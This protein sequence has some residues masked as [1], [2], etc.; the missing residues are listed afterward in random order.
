MTLHIDYP[1]HFDSRGRTART[2]T[3]E[4]IKDM[5]VQFLFTS[6][7]ERVNRPDFGAGLLRRMFEPN[8]PELAAALIFTIKAGLQ[9]WLGDLIEVGEL[10]VVANE[11]TLMVALS[12]TVRSTGE[13]DKV[14]KELKR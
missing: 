11:S 7:G 5:V 13:S 9:N 14:E 2:T 3:P 6:P 1:Y 8:S 4:H 10:D 12:Y